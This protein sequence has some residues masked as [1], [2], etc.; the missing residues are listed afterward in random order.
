[1]KKNLEWNVW[2]YDINAK[3]IKS[4][5]IFKNIGLMNSLYKLKRQL[6]DHN[7]EWFLE[8]ARKQIMYYYW[9]RSEYEI[10]IKPW[11]SEKPEVKVDIYDQVYLNWDRI[12]EYIWN[13]LKLIR[14]E[15]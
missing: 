14:K 6:K 10:I 8:E 12:S 15:K 9:A 5:N 1:M 4:Y 7:Q 13:N 2:F 11:V 3:E